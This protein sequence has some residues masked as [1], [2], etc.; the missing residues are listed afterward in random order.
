MSL[1]LSTCLSARLSVFPSV[2]SS[3]HLPVCLP[4]RLSVCPSVHL[5]VYLLVYLPVC[6][7]APLT[8][9]PSVCLP[10]CLPV[11]LSIRMSVDLSVCPSVSLPVCRHALLSVCCL[12]P[13]KYRHIINLARQNNV[14]QSPLRRRIYCW[15]AASATQ[16][17]I[18]IIIIF[19]SFSDRLIS[20]DADVLPCE[21]WRRLPNAELIRHDV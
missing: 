19:G 4:V 5:P 18:T 7:L 2:C 8:I 11:C 3:D 12:C 21:P 17:T 16:Q 6:L 13:C 10:V 1:C 14:S 9:F 20:T 15:S